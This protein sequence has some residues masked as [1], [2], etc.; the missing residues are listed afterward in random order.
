MISISASSPSTRAARSS[1][2]SDRFTPTLKLAAN[3]MGMSLP[4]STSNCF[5]SA[6]KPVVPITMALPALRQNARFFSITSGSVKSISTSNSSTTSSRLPDN[7]TPIRPSEASSPAS[8]PINVLP[9]RTIAAVRPEAGERCCTASTK[10]LPMRPAAPITAIRR[11]L[12]SLQVAEEALHAI[13]EAS[14]FRR[15]GIV[16]RQRT[17]E[18]FEQFTL[19]TA[20]VDRRF[21]RD[22]TH[23]VARTATTHRRNAFATDT[24][25]LAGLRPL[26]D[27]ELDPA[28]QGR[29]LQL[30]TQRRVDKADRH[31]AEQVLAVTL[32]DRV[33]A[34]IDHHVQI[35]RR[36]ALGPRLAFARQANAVTGIHA[37]RHFDRQGFGL[38]DTPFAVARIARVRDDLALAMAARAG[39]LHR[40]EALLHAD[41]TDPA[42]GRASDRRGAFLGTGAVAR[43]AVDQCRNTDIHGRATHR[44]FQV[45]LQGV[46]Q[47]AAAL[48]AATGTA[49]T[50]TKEV[51]EDIAKDIGEVLT[52]K[53]GTAATH[54][55][56][57]T[58]MTVLVVRRALAG[59][60]QHFVGLVGLLEHLFRR[61]VIRI[62]VRVMLHRQ[63]TVGLF[64]VCFA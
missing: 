26:R 32:E 55:W 29:N 15:M 38:F 18:L 12:N 23:Q 8:A 1:S 51:T 21:H 53:T 39:L 13:E 63:A 52:A 40:E 44:F 47:V 64:Q 2:L 37:R 58:G 28:I 36:T 50:T 42:T 61:F 59:I 49:A 4:A 16:A 56:V 17:A 20:Q 30:A 5:C 25:L 3:T 9:G 31:F 10:V 48:G 11:I 7:D 22:T 46:T 14:G 41:L 34:H 60:G 54:A 57:D 6:L 62:T 35:T 24:E 19:T 43:L 27:L 45:Q 33:L